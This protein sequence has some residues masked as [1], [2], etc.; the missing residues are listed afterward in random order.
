MIIQTLTVKNF[1]CIRDATL[2]C[3]N[4]TA[5]LGR[6][7]AGKSAFLYAIEYFY[8]IAAPFTE[9]DFFG[10]D[11]SKPVEFCITYTALREEEFEEFRS[12]I[13]DGQLIVTKR[14]VYEDGKFVQKYFGNAMQIPQFAEIRKHSKK[15]DKVSA[16]NELVTKADFPDITHRAKSADQVDSFMSE[17]E[18]AHPELRRPIEREEQF[19]GAKSVGGG[20]LDKF[21]K[22][23]LIPAV[24]E[25]SEETENKRGAISQLIDLIVL[26]RVNS[27][28]DILD[29][30]VDFE[31]RIKELYSS[32]NLSE[33]PELG[34]AISAMLETFAP[35]S[36]LKLRWD[37]AKP[38]VIQLP[39]P[40][41]TL[42]EDD[43]EGEISRKGHGL[44]RALVL[45]L[46]QQLAVAPPF[47]FSESNSA[48]DE[49]TNK[50]FPSSLDLI[51]AIE[52]P[53]LYLHPSR[54][55]YLSKL[56]LDISTNQTLGNQLTTQ[57]IYCTHSPFFVDLTRFDQVRCVKKIVRD[58]SKISES[59]VTS[60]SLEAAAEALGK[61]S[62]ID[63]AKISS[64]S[65]K[66]KASPIMNSI[67]N[68][69]F[70]ADKVVIV[71][72]MSEVGALWKMQ[73]ILKANWLEKGI[74]VIPANGKN[75][76]DRPVVIF[77]GLSIPTFFI[78]DADVKH[79]EQRKEGLEAK[80]RNHRYLR[81]ANA[82]I[83]DFPH[84]QVFFNWA[85]FHDDLESEIKK[86]LTDERF[87]E[88]RETVAAEL[89]YD[90]PSRVLKNIEGAS[91]IVEIV[92]EKGM[93]IP[94]LE[95][96]VEKIN[97]LGV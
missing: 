89:G 61:I 41:A 94:L 75:N 32:D 47:D 74:V 10:R 95:D 39:S 56:L 44:Q 58:E 64:E 59:L 48:F 6:N 27:R 71:E 54:S 14:A 25:A 35:G 53:E 17:Y 8:D 79:Q 7:G 11:I 34:D 86:A 43:F 21:T 87:E 77:R 51:I 60:F 28:K 50:L 73:E 91:R 55:R 26:R 49:S 18:N 92:Y 36:K 63:K 22:F 23:V 62:D 13:Q 16:W 42:V 45:T 52:E 78:F 83:V 9:E 82:G 5:I 31:N 24:K 15:S 81:L 19:F 30:R 4:L 85:V 12:F 76:I 20:K 97:G 72:G 93:R 65:F 29:F 68:E 2:E 1:R 46:F 40:K 80:K 84:T 33:L 66:A 37:E 67:A 90:Q 88:I 57:I 38:P 69:G 70:F 96:I 3:S